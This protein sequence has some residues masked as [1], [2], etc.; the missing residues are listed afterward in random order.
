M[1]K[2]TILGLS[3]IILLVLYYLTNSWKFA[4]VGFVILIFYIFWILAFELGLLNAKEKKENLEKTYKAIKQDH[5]KKT[6][7]NP[8]LR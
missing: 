7:N 5:I 4:I 2:Y 6:E 1:K 8:T 3:I